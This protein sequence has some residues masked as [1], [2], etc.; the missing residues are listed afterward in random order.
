MVGSQHEKLYLKGQ[1]VENHWSKISG[2]VSATRTTIPSIPCVLHTLGFQ[3]PVLELTPELQFPEFLVLP[4]LLVF[5][6]GPGAVETKRTGNFSLPQAG[7]TVP[8]PPVVSP[9]PRLL[10][11]GA[12][13]P[14][15]SEGVGTP[16]AL[17]WRCG[18]CPAPPPTALRLRM[19]SLPTGPPSLM[20]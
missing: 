10:G 9:G 2:N 5:A 8:D 1:K 19:C 20:G 15:V 3:L 6:S 16:S 7:L 14:G 18:G 12:R 17:P 4:A 11:A 13:R